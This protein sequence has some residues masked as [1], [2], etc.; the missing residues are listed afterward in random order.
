MKYLLASVF[1]LAALLAAEPV[2]ETVAGTGERDLTLQSGPVDKV[3]IA[4][5]FGVEFGPDGRLYV[6]EV[7]N[8]RIL[9]VDL[10][11]GQVE[12]VVGTGRKGYSGDGG[13]ATKANL[14]EPYEVRFDMVG[15]LYFVEMQNHIIRMVE[16]ETGRIRT[17]AGTGAQGY[18][19]DG[20]PAIKATFNRPHSIALDET[21]GHLY[22]ADIGNH[23]IRRLDLASGI[24]IGF[25]GNGRKMLPKDGARVGPDMPMI[26]PRALYVTPGMLW[27]A[28]RQG[29][30]V[31]KIDLGTSMIGHIAGT[32]KKGYS[33]DGGPA[34][35]GTFN[36]P[37]GIVLDA[38]GK[39]VYVV[40]TENQAI[41]RIHLPNGRL[42]TLAGYGPNGRGFNGD[43]IIAGKA[44]FGRPHGICV[45]P[46]GAVYTGDTLNHR[47]RRVM[48]ER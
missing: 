5:P 20:G 28:L 43:H 10:K 11:H 26:G 36:G 47:V 27:V 45:G 34:V 32:G 14:N 15:N 35:K 41:R 39:N 33:G 40:D 16:K 37:K 42:T 1:L 6:T 38:Q 13:P 12:T 17:I 23:R 3:N 8:H 19:G 31:W 22:I 29:H 46:D 48:L 25:A 44:K 4:D 21:N 18:S 2:V 9:A 30:S 7:G 24:V